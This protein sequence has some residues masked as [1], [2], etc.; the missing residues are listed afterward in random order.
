MTLPEYI[1]THLDRP[2]EWGKLDCVLFAVGWLQIAS[3][4]D[5]LS[6]Y[7]VWNDE[8]EA[9][10]LLRDLGGMETLLDK[11]LNRINPHLAR[12]GDIALR[13]N[14]MHLFSGRHIVGPGERGLVFVSRMEAECAWQS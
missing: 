10:R 9:V 11:H 12:D 8:R 1:A 7:P 5:Y 14:T 6:E 3:G 13:N 4:I 2:F